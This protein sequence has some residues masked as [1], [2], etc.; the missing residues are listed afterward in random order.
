MTLTFK[1]KYIKN[2]KLYSLYRHFR[3]PS[4]IKSYSFWAEDVFVDKC[5]HKIQ[6]GTYVDVGCNHPIHGSISYRLQQRGWS[7]VNIDFSNKNIELCKMFRPKDISF[8]CPV[9]DRESEVECYVFDEGNVLNT[10][11]KESADHWA[12]KMNKPYQVQKMKTRTL[13]SLLEESRTTRIDFLNIDVEGLEDMVLKG[14][15]IQKYKPRLIACEIHFEAVDDL[16]NSITFNTIKD[17]GYELISKIGPTCMF[18]KVGDTEIF[19]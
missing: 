6:K 2:T 10:L 3:Y 17:N 1:E 19:Y 13:T 5:L 15:D 11:D 7:G 14:F 18:R 16:K 12:K 4:Y 8:C 9:S